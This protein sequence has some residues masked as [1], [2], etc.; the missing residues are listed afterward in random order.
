MA[1]ND[2]PTTMRRDHGYQRARAS[3]VT[4][5]RV[6]SAREMSAWLSMKP[7]Q[8]QLRDLVE[9]HPH[10]RPV[11]SE[12]GKELWEKKGFFSLDDILIELDARKLIRLL[13][14]TSPQSK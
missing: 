10:L 7:Q 8:K 1:R 5:F 6:R 12:I 2:P 11:M 3:G 4:E 13:P 14:P 9:K